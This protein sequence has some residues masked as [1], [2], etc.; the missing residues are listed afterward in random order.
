MNRKSAGCIL[1]V[2]FLCVSVLLSLPAQAADT[3]N[4]SAPDAKTNS[5]PSLTSSAQLIIILLLVC[6]IV[7]LSGI[8]IAGRKK[9]K[10]TQNSEEIRRKKQASKELQL[11]DQAE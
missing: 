2:L 1:L 9:W 10:N 6:I 8:I 7:A 5:S 3:A 11:A 4:V